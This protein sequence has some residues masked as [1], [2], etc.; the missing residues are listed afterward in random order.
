MLQRIPTNLVCGI[1]GLESSLAAR[2]SIPPGCYAP[3]FHPP[4]SAAWASMGGCVA[5]IC[6][7]AGLVWSR[8]VNFDPEVS[9][10]NTV[11]TRSLTKL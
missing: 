4:T 6:T 10:D 9:N 2:S 1:S 11:N 8:C 7:D 5:C 3:L